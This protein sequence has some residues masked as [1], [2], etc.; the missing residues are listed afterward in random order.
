MDAIALL[1]LFA[2]AACGIWRAS[3]PVE[4]WIHRALMERK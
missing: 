2:L 1:F 3:E 4:E